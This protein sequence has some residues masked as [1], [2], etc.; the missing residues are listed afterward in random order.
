MLLVLEVYSLFIREG[1]CGLTYHFLVGE[2]DEA[3][4][5]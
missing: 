3:S 1:N 4:Q 2:D 5:K